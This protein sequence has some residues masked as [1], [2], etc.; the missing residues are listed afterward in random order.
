MHLKVLKFSIKILVLVVI[1]TK[2]LPRYLKDYFLTTSPLW[3]SL[4]ELLKSVVAREE[5]PLGCY[6]FYQPYNMLNTNL[7]IFH[8]SSPDV[9]HKNLVNIHLLTIE[10]SIYNNPLK[11]KV[12][13]LIIMTLLLLLMLFMPLNILEIH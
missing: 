3:L 10:S 9:P 5:P 11:Y 4:C 12:F 6:L 13:N 2:L 8:L 1:L 7:P